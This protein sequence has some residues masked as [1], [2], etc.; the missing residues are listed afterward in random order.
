MELV[1]TNQSFI[2]L[3]SPKLPALMR[4]SQG[5]KGVPKKASFNSPFNPPKESDYFS[6]PQCVPCNLL[7]GKKELKFCKF[8]TQTSMLC[9]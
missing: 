2:G 1:D 4:D 5:L 8:I 9:K 6:T 7:V 3:S